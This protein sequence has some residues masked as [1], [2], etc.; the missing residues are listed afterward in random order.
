MSATDQKNQTPSV[1]ELEQRLTD[2]L[3]ADDTLERFK[4]RQERLARFMPPVKHI[5]RSSGQHWFTEK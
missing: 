4:E 5:R 2:R 3:E 1:E